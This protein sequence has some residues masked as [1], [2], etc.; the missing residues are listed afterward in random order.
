MD[1]FHALSGTSPAGK[2]HRHALLADYLARME[3]PASPTS[4]A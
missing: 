2:L 4:Q 1:L 3:G